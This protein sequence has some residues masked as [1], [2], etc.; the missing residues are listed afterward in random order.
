VT[1]AKRKPSKNN[2][3]L[4]KKKKRINEMKLVPK[5]QK[6]NNYIIIGN[7]PKQQK[8]KLEEPL[9]EH[10]IVQEIR[11]T[12]KKW[13]NLEVNNL[14]EY[15]QASSKLTRSEGIFLD[16]GTTNTEKNYVSNKISKTYKTKQND[17]QYRGTFY[18]LNE[19]KGQDLNKR[20]PE[21][22]SNMHKILPPPDEQT[23]NEFTLVDPIERTHRY[24]G[25]KKSSKD[26]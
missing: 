2:L 1:T 14:S 5:V 25:I 9:T 21:R 10:F 16:K 6:R 12:P 7:Q 15:Q 13:M 11:D 19:S 20:N 22:V 24:R 23:I 18:K 26:Q 3:I 8:F 4:I 17:S